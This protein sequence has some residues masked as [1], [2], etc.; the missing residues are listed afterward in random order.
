MAKVLSCSFIAGFCILVS[1]LSHADNISCSRDI[2]HKDGALEMTNVVLT[3]EK[4]LIVGVSVD[5]CYGTGQGGQGG[6]GGCC[7]FNTKEEEPPAS[8]SSASPERKVVKKKTL[9]PSQSVQW[10]RSDS[11]TK[12]SLDYE[13]KKSKVVITKQSTSYIVEFVDMWYGY[14]GHW[15]KGFPKNVRLEQG[16]KECVVN[17]KAL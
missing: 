5:A 16:K 8:P 2:N 3:L 7:G 12:L 4:N 6:Q 9:E 14:C 15:A 11:V 1:G 13:G 17:E 10:E